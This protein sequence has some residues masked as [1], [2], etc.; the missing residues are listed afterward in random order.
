MTTLPQKQ[1]RFNLPADLRAQFNRLCFRANYSFVDSYALAHYSNAF[2]H[3]YHSKP[4]AG[5]TNIYHIGA[6][7]LGCD[8]AVGFGE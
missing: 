3:Q 1:T 5:C 2:H 6:D 4:G 8:G 7:C